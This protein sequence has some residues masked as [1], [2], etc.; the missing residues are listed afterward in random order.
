MF[1][2]QPMAV[3]HVTAAVFLFVAVM[4]TAGCGSE[5]VDGNGDAGTG[6]ASPQPEKPEVTLKILSYEDFQQLVAGHKGKVVVVDVWSTTCP[7]CMKE[8]PGLVALHKQH[9]PDKV[10]CVSLSLDYIG[11]KDK[12]PEAYQERVLDFLRTREATF[13]NVLCSESADDVLNLL[14]LGG[15]PAVYVYDR[16]GKLAKRFD[17]ESIQNEEDAFTYQDVNELVSKLLADTAE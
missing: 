17:N 13:D 6:T 2:R 16:Q 10:A 4:A 8:F 14:E 9:G 3:V 1:R 12:P 7:P 5:A 15:P 11:L